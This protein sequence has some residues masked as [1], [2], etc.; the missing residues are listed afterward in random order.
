MRIFRLALVLL[1]SLSS[2]NFAQAQWWTVQASGIDT[3]LR[4]VSAV[5]VS[6]E[7]S[8]TFAV[9]AAGSN[10]VIL[11][12]LDE[13]KYWKRL[14]V[15]DGD[16]LNFRGIAAFD[17]QTA[18]VMSVGNGE[19]SRIYKTTDGGETWKLQFTGPR[20]ETFLDGIV[21]DSK[22]SCMVLGDP[23]DGKFL[24]LFTEDGEHWKELSREK[25]PAA[26]PNEGAFAASNSSLC[27]D[28]DDVYFATGGAAKARVFHS[29]DR[30]SA[31]TVAETP[32]ASGNATSG[33]F[34]LE[35]KNV[36][37]LYAVGGDYEDPTRAFH[38]AAY[39]H[40]PDSLLEGGGSWQLSKQQ[41]GGFRS[42]VAGV[43]GATV[44]AVGPNGED[45]SH[46]LGV[47]WSHTDS[48]NLNAV[49]F[50]DIYD[51]WA[52]GPKGTIAR[53]LNQ[54]QYQIRNGAPDQPCV[55]E[56][57][58]CLLDFA[59]LSTLPRPLQS[60]FASSLPFPD[61]NAGREHVIQPN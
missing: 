7:G 10:G 9:W 13:G 39:L 20:K 58:C 43:D 44:V 34:S 59:R 50:V 18:Y 36:R 3:D 53:F 31:W 23:I 1:L 49:T 32:I 8:G 27:L 2:A 6:A 51:G 57:D 41:P 28:N 40:T 52:V 60:D 46:D 38:S 5:M 25:M 47:T 48:F 42:G 29:P 56:V 33:I 14:H 22:I 45:I 12:S 11:R 17:A 61:S 26:L 15:A 16:T 4:A 54:M 55:G 19:K 35:C 21:C 30:G 37:I 24:I